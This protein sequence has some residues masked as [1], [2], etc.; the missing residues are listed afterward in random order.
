MCD[1][2][3]VNCIN[4]VLL[5]CSNNMMWWGDWLTSRSLI[6]HFF[7]WWKQREESYKL[8]LEAPIFLNACFHQSWA[9]ENRPTP[10][11]TSPLSHHWLQCFPLSVCHKCTRSIIPTALWTSRSLSTAPASEQD[12]RYLF[13]TPSLEGEKHK[14]IQPLCEEL[15]V[16]SQQAS[17]SV[18]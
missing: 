2:N 16:F 6:L 18:R 4:Y 9:K 5:H 11:S 15:N 12:T 1:S 7:L 10:P 3:W 8:R 17:H 13:I 14:S